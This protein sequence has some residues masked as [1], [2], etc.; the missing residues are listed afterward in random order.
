MNSTSLQI[1]LLLCGGVIK[2][3][4]RKHEKR[5]KI[6]HDDLDK[7]SQRSDDTVDIATIYKNPL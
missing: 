1:T 2:K 7:R 6:N 4:Q 5:L 3:M